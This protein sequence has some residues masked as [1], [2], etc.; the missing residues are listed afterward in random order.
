MSRKS[1]L[2][3]FIFQSSYLQKLLLSQLQC[4][5]L[6]KCTN[7]YFFSDDEIRECVFLSLDERFDPHLAQAESLTT[8]FVAMHDGVSL[9]CPCCC[10]C[11]AV[12]TIKGLYAL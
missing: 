1:L 8:L 5:L 10:M 12:Y 7:I 2:K 9:P 3:A 4:T 11:S 6:L